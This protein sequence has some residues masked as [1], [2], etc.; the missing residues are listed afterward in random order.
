MKPIVALML[1]SAPLTSVAEAK[2]APIMSANILT[3][4]GKSAGTATLM[5]T[6]DGIGVKIIMKKLSA[7]LHGVHI[8]SVGKC[9]GPKFVSA[10][11]HFNPTGR[12]HGTANPMGTHQ[13]DLPNLVADRK[14]RAS[15]DFVISS[16]SA[17]DLYD[18]DGAAIVIHAKPDDNQTDPSGN[19]GDRIACGV[20]TQR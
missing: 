13:G 11:P 20:F 2:R 17:N 3:A 19:S 15:L 6:A 1:I 5:R 12:Q 4:A 18:A 8:H 9:E 14:G 7:G 16:A 10:G